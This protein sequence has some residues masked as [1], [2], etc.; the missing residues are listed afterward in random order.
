M[1]KVLN[2]G[3]DVG[4]TTVKM[5]IL[6]EDNIIYKKYLRHFSDI[7][8]TVLSLFEDAKSVMERNLMTIMVTGSGGFNISQ[9][10]QVPF[11]Q[12]VMACI[13]AVKRL[14]PNADVAIELGGE[15]AKIT[16]FGDSVEQRMNGTCAGGTGAFID[17]MA[18]LLQ[19]DPSG[20]NDLAKKHNNIY[21]IASRCGVFAKT[22]IQPLLNEGAAK[23]DI[24]ASVL[25]AVVNQTISGL[26]QGRHISGHVAFLGGPLHFMSE[27]RER[28]IETL[29][30]EDD[31]VL[32]PEDSQYFVALGAALSSRDEQ[33]FSFECLYERTPM[34]YRLNHE[35]SEE[36]EPLFSDGEEYRLFNERHA[37]HKV[38]RVDLETYEGNAYL[39]IDAGSTTTK[40]ALI[41]EDGG[42]LYSYYG[43]NMGS[44]LES[45]IEALK[46]LYS[47]LNQRTKIAN[48]AVTG[49][50]EHLI[51]AALKV[52]IGE[53]ETVG[54]ELHKDLLG[55]LRTRPRPEFLPGSH[56]AGR[57]RG[58]QPGLERRQ[59][60]GLRAA[61]RIP[62]YGDALRVHVGPGEKVINGPYPVPHEVAGDVGS[63]EQALDPFHRVLG[64]AAGRERAL[65]GYR[66]EILQAFSLA[67]RIV[68]QH[69]EA[70]P[71][72]IGPYML[73]YVVG[74]AVTT[75]ARRPQD[76]GEGRPRAG[77]DVN[78]GGHVMPGLAFEDQLLDPVAGAVER[79]G[80]SRV[81]RRPVGPAADLLEQPAADILLARS[82]FGRGSD[83][84]HGAGA[85]L[86]LT[87]GHDRQIAVHH[88]L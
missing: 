36:L 64:R 63:R 3:L 35:E 78:I 27:L 59:V 72:E 12:E 47:K 65:A 14:I 56:V 40:I 46:G 41:S 49:Y 62:C 39:G 37:R 23:E 18:A 53:I 17:Q 7:K 66:V 38:E 10:L 85:C 61:T 69:E 21:P 50:G 4:S 70:A 34:I 22:D 8:N 84:R 67:G 82:H 52:D 60:S 42:L 54:Q 76:R 48:S 9:K 73:V 26:A 83:R 24:A 25:Q 71:G 16:Y 32:F 81:E 5:V 1:K 13:S 33:P 44:P 57:R 88:V 29:K 30:L 75:V 80:D 77:R 51:K 55:V 11:I 20:L 58:R 31:G 74:L 19:T 15:D 45:T 6:D 68:C 87:R 28:F 2:V 86:P 79:A 43:S